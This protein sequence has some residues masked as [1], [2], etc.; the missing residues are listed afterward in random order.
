VELCKLLNDLQLTQA[1]R[2]SHVLSTYDNSHVQCQINL[3]IRTFTMHLFKPSDTTHEYQLHD[4]NTRN[5]FVV[6]K[7]MFPAKATLKVAVLLTLAVVHADGYYSCCDGLCYK[8][9]NNTDCLCTNNV[10]C[11][12]NDECASIDTCS[13]PCSLPA[14]HCPDTSLKC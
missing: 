11:T 8:Q 9:C 10:K 5:N 2:D 4:F 13:T 1:Q 14:N 7:I 6:R 12:K 3:L